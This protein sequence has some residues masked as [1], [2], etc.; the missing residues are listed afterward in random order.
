[1]LNPIIYAFTVEDFKTSLKQL[2]SWSTYRNLNIKD[3]EFLLKINGTV[4]PPTPRSPRNVAKSSKS[5]NSPSSNLLRP[6][7]QFL[8]LSQTTL[9]STSDRNSYYV[10]DPSM[11]NG[12]IQNETTVDEIVSSTADFVQNSNDDEIGEKSL[13]AKLYMMLISSKSTGV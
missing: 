1:M 5:R 2:F 6:N 12:E 11:S 8:D 9:A 10:P 7:R 4:P 13:S 3:P